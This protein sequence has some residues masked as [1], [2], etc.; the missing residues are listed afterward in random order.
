MTKYKIL[1]SEGFKKAEKWCAK[2]VEFQSENMEERSSFLALSH[3]L[4]GRTDNTSLASSQAPDALQLK[5]MDTSF[6]EGKTYNNDSRCLIS[7]KLCLRSA[8]ITP[9]KLKVKQ[10]FK[11]RI[12]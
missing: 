1:F 10:I 4:L 2:C 11:T 6:L 7:R 12:R 9:H 8:N 5:K 3:S